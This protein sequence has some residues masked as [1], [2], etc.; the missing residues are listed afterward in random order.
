M[1]STAHTTHLLDVS[2]LTK[3]FRGLRA[4][5]SVNLGVDSGEILGVIG[6]N[7]AGKTTLFNCLSG[8]LHPMEGSVV[9]RDRN[10]TGL[11]MP[12]VTRLGVTRTFRNIRL[13][14]SMSALDNVRTAQ[15][16]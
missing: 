13:F 2:N 9:F 3:S 16:S 4:L 12:A 7:G 8:Y 15:Q 10:I 14:G 6:P 1:T 11:R 5:Q